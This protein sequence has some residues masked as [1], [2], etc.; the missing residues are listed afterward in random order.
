M[1]KCTTV[2][3]NWGVVDNTRSVINPATKALFP[4]SSEVEQDNAINSID[5]NSNGFKIRSADGRWN[6]S[7]ATYIFIAFAEHP[8]KYSTAK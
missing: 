3:E 1:V 7:G 4:N 2:A 6:Q 5:F 8:F